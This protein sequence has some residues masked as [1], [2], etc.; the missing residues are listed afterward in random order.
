M[1]LF[2]GCNIKI[3]NLLNPTWLLE[4]RRPWLGALFIRQY[5]R[6]AMNK[7]IQERSSREDSRCSCRCRSGTCTSKPMWWWR[8][9]RARDQEARCSHSCDSAGQQQIQ[10]WVC[11]EKNET[12]IPWTVAGCKQS[13]IDDACAHQWMTFY[14][15]QHCFH[16]AKND[17]IKTG[18]VRVIPIMQKSLRS[19]SVSQIRVWR[20]KKPKPRKPALSSKVQ[21][22][23]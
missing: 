8:N 21:S 12:R 20:H 4:Q 10:D 2:S 1:S 17:L 14:N 13:A 19:A 16:D 22:R 15:F 7:S 18:L 3:V 9:E 11:L 5:A 23:S 6:E